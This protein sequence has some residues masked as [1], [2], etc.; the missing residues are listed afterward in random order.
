MQYSKSVADLRPSIFPLRT[1]TLVFL[2]IVGFFGAIAS[3]WFFEKRAIT[4]LFQQLYFWQENPPFWIAVPEFSH[5]FLIFLP[6]VIL[7]SI[8]YSVMKLS[9]QPK[10]WSRVII[11]G[12]LLALTIR[13]LLWRSLSTL[14]LSNPLD[15][16]FSLAL[17]F[18]EIMVIAGGTIQIYLTLQTTDRRAEADK[19]SQAVQ[20]GTYTPSVDILIPTYNEPGFVLRRTIIGCQAINYPNKNIYLLDDTQRPEVKQLAQDLG[21]YYITRPDNRY[22]KAGNLNHAI[23]KTDGE[24]LVVF[25]ADFIPTQNFLTRTVGFFQK[26][27]IALVQTPQ[28]FYNSDPTAKN[29]GLQEVLPAEEDIFY[30]HVQSLKDGAG[31]VVCAGTSFVVRRSALL[32][33]GCFVTDSI[34][35]DYYTGIR[36]SAQGYELV[37]LNENLSAGLAAESM[38]AHILQRVRWARGTLQGFFIDS[39]PLTISGLRLRQRLAHLE[40]YLSWLAIIP[41]LFFLLVPIF[42]TFFG[43][44]PLIVTGSEMI[45]FFLPYYLLQLSAFTWLNQ[46]SRSVIFSDIY[47]MVSCFPL[48]ITV[49]K[50]ILNP[51]SQGF[52]VTPKGLFRGNY[53]YNW[54]LA[55][56]LFVF[57]VSTILSTVISLGNNNYDVNLVL[58]WNS[59]NLLILSVALLSLLDTPKTDIY[60]WLPIQ[61]S[62]Q[63]VSDRKSICGTITKI[64]EIGAEI[65]FKQ[66]IDLN[67]SLFVEI[68]ERELRLPA[69]LVCTNLTGNYTKI[70]VQFESLNLYQYRR[71]VELNFCRPGQW[72]RRNTPGELRSICIAIAVL[73]R[74]IIFFI[75]SRKKTEINYHLVNFH[76]LPDGKIK[77]IR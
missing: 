66:F 65:E 57:F 50:V 10:T 33:V 13:Y 26:K 45:Y 1:A 54:Q 7:F 46:R 12:I 20:T 11:V 35:E 74:P 31:S 40:G 76:N 72:M 77:S 22:A 47:A 56:P 48:F 51:F 2:G 34:S 62:V 27:E 14:N 67:N 4:E 53:Q 18:M 68:T 5:P 9:P 21:C 61:Q 19:Y 25:D 60:E 16:I 59:Y 41:R 64:S 39:N 23:A 8:G 37:Y 42:Y 30:R 71:L 75:R 43:I 63:V 36:L 44:K 55:L 38:S 28:S 17:L 52:K 73:F 49:I 15:G 69:N 3:A 29:L 24:L 70:R 58:I 6:T 32:E